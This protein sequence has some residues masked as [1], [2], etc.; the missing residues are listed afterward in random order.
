[1]TDIV[2]NVAD[3]ISLAE[4]V[5]QGLVVSGEIFGAT[6]TDDIG[7]VAEESEELVALLSDWFGGTVIY[8]PHDA[9]ENGQLIEAI[10]NEKADLVTDI[11]GGTRVYVPKLDVLRRRCRNSEILKMRKRGAGISGIARRFSL[12][13]RQVQNILQRMSNSPEVIKR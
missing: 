11:L 12:S 7:L 3:G 2:A 6:S 1:M 9:K 10:G 4:A 5:I 8:I 13:D